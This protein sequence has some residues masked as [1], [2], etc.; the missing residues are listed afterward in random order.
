MC[1]QRCQIFLLIEPH[2]GYSTT[3]SVASGSSKA[4][5][6]VLFFRIVTL[7]LSSDLPSPQQLTCVAASADARPARSGVC[8]CCDFLVWKNRFLAWTGWL[9]LVPCSRRHL[10]RRQRVKIVQTLTHFQVLQDCSE[11]GIFSIFT[12]FC[13]Q[14][15]LFW[16]GRNG[17]YKIK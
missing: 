12:V 14:W 1:T 6:T 9:F 4:F 8:W 16:V 13:T 11:C 7:S 2:S 5:S 17:A 3:V 15:P 10:T